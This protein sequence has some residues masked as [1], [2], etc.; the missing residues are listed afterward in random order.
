M[1]TLI[2]RVTHRSTEKGCWSIKKMRKYKLCVTIPG[3]ISS[4]EVLFLL[5]R[6]VLFQNPEKFSSQSPKKF[7]F[8][9]SNNSSPENSF[10]H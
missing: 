7:L 4:Q 3:R 6:R 1:F 10:L 9:F 8:P 2:N 5:V